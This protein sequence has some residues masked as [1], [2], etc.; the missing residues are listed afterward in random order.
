MIKLK[1][2]SVKPGMHLAKSIYTDEGKLLID[3]GVV[4][5]E[6]YINKL[7]S[8]G[9]SNIYVAWESTMEQQFTE[10]FLEDTRREAIALAEESLKE[11]H[12]YNRLSVEKLKALIGKLVEDLLLNKSTRVYLTDIRAIDEYTFGHSVNVCVFSLMMGI[13]LE[14]RKE[15]LVEL[16]VGAILHDIGKVTIDNAVLNKPSE[17]ST[18]EFE[19]IKQHPVNGYQL[20]KQLKGISEASCQVVRDHH[21]RFD[22]KGYPNGLKGKKI[23]LYSRIVAICDVYDALTSNRVYKNK[24]TPHY[25]IEYLISMGNHQFDY[26]LVKVFLQNINIYP[27]GT[28]VRLKSG[29]ACIVVADNLGWP[30]RPVVEIKG[31]SFEDDLGLQKK[32]DLT[33]QLNYSIASTL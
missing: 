27:V 12:L 2:S 33:K 15:E 8:L 23:H 31:N 24:A 29:E 26:D 22:G 30:T 17:L 13:M 10:I 3:K 19:I 6:T 14:L 28:H 18:Q 16:G 1:L 7:A 11:I 5:K 21:E 4:L 20:V 32:I 9:C 25:A